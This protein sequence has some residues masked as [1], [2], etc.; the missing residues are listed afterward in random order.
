MAGCYIV[1]GA[2]EREY[3]QAV[4]AGLDAYITVRF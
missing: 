1:T 2:A 3:H 4:A